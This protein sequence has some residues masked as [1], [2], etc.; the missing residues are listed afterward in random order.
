MNRKWFS[1]IALVAAATFLFNLSSCA[2]NQHLVS[3]AVS[4]Q[5]TTITLTGVG[6][7]V[8]TQFTA[9]GTYIHPPQTRDITSTAVWTTDTPTIIFADPTTPGLVTTT[10][11]GCGTNLG[12]SA[13]VYSNPSNPSSGSVVVGTAT[14]NV[15]F[16]SGSSCP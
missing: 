7:Q 9:L 11:N 4:P 3:I 5:G 6:Q 13:K 1:I 12:V 8:S 2:F 15:S 16:G 14:M 10:G